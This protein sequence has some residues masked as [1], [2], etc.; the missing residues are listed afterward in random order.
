MGTLHRSAAAALEQYENGKDTAVYL[1]TD[2][3]PVHLL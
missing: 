1:E 2:V 3:D